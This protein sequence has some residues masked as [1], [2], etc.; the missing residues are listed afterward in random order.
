MLKNIRELGKQTPVL[1]GQLEPRWRPSPDWPEGPASSLSPTSV[2][3]FA[4][5]EE[6]TLKVIRRCKKSVLAGPSLPNRNGQAWWGRWTLESQDR[7]GGLLQ[8]QTHIHDS[9]AAGKD[10]KI[11]VQWEKGPQLVMLRHS[12]Q[13]I[14]SA[15]LCF[16]TWLCSPSLAWSVLSRVTAHWRAQAEQEVLTLTPVIT[17]LKNYSLLLTE[18]IHGQ[19]QNSS[20]RR[21]GN[22]CG[23]S[24]WHWEDFTYP[25]YSMDQEEQE[26]VT[27]TII[28]SISCQIGVLTIFA[29]EW[30]LAL[31]TGKWSCFIS[32]LE[33]SWILLLWDKGLLSYN[34]EVQRR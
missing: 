26:I 3:V 22:L 6:M 4:E 25:K 1:T 24:T 15:M 29:F 7:G 31:Q 20:P 12:H 8:K 19:E 23:D 30:C 34:G 14:Q 28:T 21:V 17:S 16:H 9:W 32:Q 13:E 33:V 10:A 5:I 18:L 2:S 27:G 11:T